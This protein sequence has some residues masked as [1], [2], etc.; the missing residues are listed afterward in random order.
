[1]EFDTNLRN[2]RRSI[3]DAKVAGATYRTG[4]ELEVRHRLAII[5]K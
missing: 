4:P 2:I 1:M 3:L 5:P